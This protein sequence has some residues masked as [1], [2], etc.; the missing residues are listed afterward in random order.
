MKKYTVEIEE[1]LTLQVE[2]MANEPSDAET[3]IRER[4]KNGDFVLD[5]SNHFNT[6]F[7]TWETVS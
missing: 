6:M 1:T 5:E 3:I 7:S 2:V 4:Y